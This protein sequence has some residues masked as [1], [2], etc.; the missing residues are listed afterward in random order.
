[1][2]DK[3]IKQVRDA[4]LNGNPSIV[5]K[6]AG[7]ESDDQQN[8]N[9]YLPYTLNRDLPTGVNMCQSNAFS[10][11]SRKIIFHD[12]MPLRNAIMHHRNVC[13]FTIYRNKLNCSV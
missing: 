5:M 2:R 12:L 13:I 8:Q 4:T 6:W 10:L 1:M 3:K 11:I 7:S 9:R